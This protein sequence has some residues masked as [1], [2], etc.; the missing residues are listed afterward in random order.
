ML[1]WHEFLAQWSKDLWA[2]GL[3]KQIV[4]PPASPDWLGFP[5]ATYDEIGDLENRL[6]LTLPPSYRAFLKVSN[7]WQRTNFFISHIR[8]TSGVD[9]FRVENENWVDIFSEQGDDHEDAKYFQ[10]TIDGAE[11]HRAAHMKFLL[12]ISDVG[13]GVYLLNPEAVTP[14][15]E[16]EAW[17]FA[18]WVPGA[19]RYPSFAHLM[20]S[21]YRSFAQVEGVDIS[22]GKLPLL[23]VPNS[24]V[25]R[26]KAKRRRKQ[27]SRALTLEAL[28]VKM[29]SPNA[30]ERDAAIMAFA[31]KLK[32]RF[33]AVRRP[34]LVSP[35]CELYYSSVEPSVRGVCVQAL[36]EIADDA[37]APKPLF[38][39]LT[40]DHPSVILAGI[41][42][43]NYFP[44]PQALGPLCHF[45]ES[46]ANAVYNEN[47][48]HALAEMRDPRAV[49]TLAAVLLDTQTP[50]AQNIGTAA[51]ALARCGTSGFDALVAAMGHGDARVRRAVVV[52]LDCSNDPR[53]RRFLDQMESD[54]D[55]DVR[56]RLRSCSRN[57]PR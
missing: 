23:E 48:M 22:S 38:D 43:L 46:R 3:A 56:E 19:S 4:P 49:A 53:A 28:V 21:E 10:Y 30:G 17:F 24:R 47:A 11:G 37:A 2:S 5:P 35:I 55:P 8:P 50:F 33:R 1:D 51:V 52:G 57:Q 9:W 6:G 15:G 45:I 42:A 7:G 54:P 13:D 32:G 26:V 20:L 29:G 25:A 12:Q 14:D 27:P 16:W 41:C 18:N 36:T 31:G 34:D 39:A 44:N 40:D